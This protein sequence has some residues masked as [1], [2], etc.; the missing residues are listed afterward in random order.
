MSLIVSESFSGL[1]EFARLSD[2]ERAVWRYYYK[3][4]KRALRSKKGRLDKI[5]AHGYL[6][7]DSMARNAK[8]P[9]LWRGTHRGETTAIGKKG[10]F[11]SK[12]RRLKNTPTGTYVAGNPSFTR[13]YAVSAAAAVNN[14][15]ALH[16]SRVVFGGGLEKQNVADT[17][18]QARIYGIAPRAL[19]RADNKTRAWIGDYAS[20]APIRHG[21]R[22]SEVRALLKPKQ[23]RFPQGGGVKIQWRAVP[24]GEIERNKFAS[25]LR[26]REFSALRKRI[27]VK[28]HPDGSARMTV[29]NSYGGVNEIGRIQTMAKPSSIS[30]K[31]GTNVGQVKWVEID[32]KFRG[33]GLAT[34]MYGEAMKQA[35]RGRLVSDS[36]QYGGGTAIWNRLQRN[37]G[38]KIRENPKTY[39]GNEDGMVSSDERPLF[40]GRINPAAIKQSKLRSREFSA[41]ELEW[42]LSMN[43][44][45]DDA[46]T[47]FM[48]LSTA[49]KLVRAIKNDK[50][51]V[52][53][54]PAFI[55]DSAD[56][57]EQTIRHPRRMAQVR[58]GKW[59]RHGELSRNRMETL[60]H[61]YGHILAH[62]QGAPATKKMM[63][64]A[65][66][67]PRVY[68][69]TPRF[70]ESGKHAEKYYKRLF[71]SEVE[72]NRAAKQWI[73]QNGAPEDIKEY[74]RS[75]VAPLKSYR[76][77]WR[78]TRRDIDRLK[79]YRA[80]ELTLPE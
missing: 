67:E 54:P 9:L 47:E 3:R 72:A 35:P 16:Q 6:P 31:R 13:G 7:G 19:N 37:K 22:R 50:V 52:R 45:L 21:I 8:N 53:R 48:R 55:D 74:T 5:D 17:I 34:K 1:T 4:N 58:G 36:A 39:S 28:W 76:E 43:N 69:T 25:K 38:Y 12:W 51:E 79:R 60:A 40:I 73:A 66:R 42:A 14:R 57:L 15:G 77:A 10:K 49:K 68:K 26:L 78:E 20:T 56:L 71:K 65:E 44:L 41:R 24:L 61:E 29:P 32:P 11:A 2:A 64:S 33:M 62:K 23:V 80:G 46:L 75:S 70:K 59:Q 27:R 18:R 30:A 63:R